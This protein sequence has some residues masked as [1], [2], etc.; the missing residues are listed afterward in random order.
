V[1]LACW[2]K[3]T[4]VALKH[5]DKKYALTGGWGFAHFNENDGKPVD[6]AVLKT[7]FP[8]HQAIKDRDMVFTR[9]AP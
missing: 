1:L 4:L 9:Y 5:H 3:A 8:C 2:S 6:E 7:C